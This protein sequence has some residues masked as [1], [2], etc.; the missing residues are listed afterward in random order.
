LKAIGG[1]DN[2]GSARAKTG[3]EELTDP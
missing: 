1:V 3:H 2:S